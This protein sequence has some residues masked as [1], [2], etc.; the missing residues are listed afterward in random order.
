LVEIENWN[1][2]LIL[3]GSYEGELLRLVR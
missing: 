3:E 1:Q 2:S